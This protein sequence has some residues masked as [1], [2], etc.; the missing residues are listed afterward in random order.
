VQ[1]FSDIRPAPQGAGL[2]FDSESADSALIA[3]AARGMEGLQNQTDGISS[4]CLWHLRK[5]ELAAVVT[6]SE[7]DAALQCLWVDFW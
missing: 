6:K 4:F 3:R 7:Q 1:V 5:T 2:L